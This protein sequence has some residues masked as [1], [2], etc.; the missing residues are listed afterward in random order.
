MNPEVIEK[1][2][3]CPRLPSLPA[4]AMRVIELTQKADVSVNEIAQTITN[5]QGLA[6]KVLR[7]VNSPF[8]AM[9]KPCASI[10]QA[11]VMLGLSAVKTLALGFSLVSSVQERAEGFDY[12]QYWKRCLVS[13]VAAKCIAAESKSGFDEECFLGGLLQDVGMVALYQALG[14][15]YLSIVAGAAND[16]RLLAKEE[17]S[18]LELTHADIGALLAQR[19]K[20]PPELVMPVKFHERPGAAPQQYLAVCQAVGLGNI[21]ADILSSPEPAVPLKKF[22]AK[23]QEWFS[24]NNAQCDAIVKATTLGVDEVGKLLQLSAGPKIN[25]DEL[26]QKATDE[27]AAI[28]MPFDALPTGEFDTDAETGLPSRTVFNQNVVAAFEIASRGV[29]PLSIAVFEI[30]GWEQIK[31][32]LGEHTASAF[33]NSLAGHLQRFFDAHNGMTCRFDQARFGVVIAR[34]DRAAATRL[35]EQCRQQIASGG[36]VAKAPGLKEAVVQTTLS[37]GLA[38]LDATTAAKF[39]EPEALISTVVA[40]LDAAIRAGGKTMRVYTPRAAA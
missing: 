15:E 38:T 25:A 4:V 12:T 16:H 3:A 9:R 35:C 29:S 22:Y 26:L 14:N 17:M 5:D 32:S 23:A 10:N 27:L 28:A 34:T 24:L 1:V 20:L 19:W 13:G 11:I 7:T 33:L 8:Y 36:V 18:A 6:T 39:V 37:A 2:L 21:V 31:A 40:A 30:D